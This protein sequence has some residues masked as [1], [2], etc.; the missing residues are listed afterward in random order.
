MDGAIADV[1]LAALGDQMQHLTAELEH[2]SPTEGLSP[3]GASTERA[4]GPFARRSPMRQRTH[5]RGGCD[6]R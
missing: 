1:Q 6:V 4:T 2:E 5:P 3:P